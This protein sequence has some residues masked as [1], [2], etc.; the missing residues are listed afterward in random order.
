MQWEN[1]LD[2][3]KEK[4]AFSTP[5]LQKRYPHIGIF[6]CKW[7]L[8]DVFCVIDSVVNIAKK[9]GVLGQHIIFSKD[10]GRHM[11]AWTHCPFGTGISMDWKQYS[12]IG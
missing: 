6:Q 12:L 5:C 7:Q 2:K 11:V 9:K 3:P 8:G 10:N 1:A 4:T